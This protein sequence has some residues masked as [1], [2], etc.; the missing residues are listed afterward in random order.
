MNILG[1]IKE[2]FVRLNLNIFKWALKKRARVVVFG[3]KIFV[4]GKRKLLNEGA[5]I[6]LR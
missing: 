4:I 1:E 2:L 3:G 5:G 6:V